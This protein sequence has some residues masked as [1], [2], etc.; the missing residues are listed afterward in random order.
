MVG[1]IDIGLGN[2]KSITNWLDRCVVPWKLI[3]SPEDTQGYDLIILPGVGSVLEFMTKLEQLQFVKFLQI[4][5]EQGQRI[6]GI[7]LG[8]HV[9]FNHSEEDGGVKGLGIIQGAVRHI[10]WK[11]SNTGWLPCTFDK[12]QMHE[13]WKSQKQNLS[14]KQRVS[15]RVFFNHNYGI[16]LE[17]AADLDIKIQTSELS[18]F[19]ALVHKKNLMACQFHPEKSQMMGELLLKMIL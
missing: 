4:K 17:E 6:L 8:A 15:G 13:L 9:L 3:Q 18:D 14:R 7:C 5:S 2:I 16:Q 11:S 19:S 12:R 1:I 10:P